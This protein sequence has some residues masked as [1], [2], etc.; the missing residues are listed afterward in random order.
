MAKTKTNKEVIILILLIVSLYI[1]YLIINELGK[2]FVHIDDNFRS[3][4]LRFFVANG[5]DYSIRSAPDIFYLTVIF[6]FIILLS[7]GFVAF[8][9]IKQKND[10]N[11]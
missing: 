6:Q 7:L 11:P 5:G 4:P 3:N 9:Q 10:R 1:I 2:G 8:L